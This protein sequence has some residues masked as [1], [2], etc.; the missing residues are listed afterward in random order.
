MYRPGRKIHRDN[1]YAS[2]CQYLK[3]NCWMVIEFLLG[4]MKRFEM[5]KWQSQEHH[6]SRVVNDV[7]WNSENRIEELVKYICRYI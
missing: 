4:E 3:S 2:D 6:E 7:E 5:N 1:M